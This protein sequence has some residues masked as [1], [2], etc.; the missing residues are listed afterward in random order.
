[1]EL[2]V[3][4]SIEIEVRSNDPHI[5]LPSDLLKVR[6]L[7]CT[8]VSRLLQ[9]IHS[10][11]H[12]RLLDTTNLVFDSEG[13][14]RD[15]GHLGPVSDYCLFQSSR[16]IP[17]DET[18]RSLTAEVT[19]ERRTLGG[20]GMAINLDYD[21]EDMDNEFKS[22]RVHYQLNTLSMCDKFI[23]N[24]KELEKIS[25]DTSFGNLKSNAIE[26]V[27]EY[28]SNHE[29]MC[30]LG[31]KH[32][33]SDITKFK[34]QGQ[35]DSTIMPQD[36]MRLSELLGGIDISPS[37]INYVTAMFCIEHSQDIS[38][39][40][41]ESLEV[42][43][44]VSDVGLSMHKMT[45]DSQTT[46]EQVK[47]FICSI[48]KHSKDISP[49]DIKLIYRG[50]LLR[51]LNDDG[52]NTLILDL[53][54]AGESSIK[55][56][57]LF[58]ADHLEIE[59]EFWDN[60]SVEQVNVSGSEEF[61]SHG[62][63]VEVESVFSQDNAVVRFF[64]ESGVE[65]QPTETLYKK[66]IVDG[67]EVFIEANELEPVM[68]H[69]I[70]QG[71]KVP[72]TN[73]EY[74]IIDGQ[75]NLSGSIIDKIA[76]EFNIH[77]PRN[78]PLQK[79]RKP[80]PTRTIPLVMAHRRNIWHRIVQFFRTGIPLTILLLRTLYLLAKNSLVT[81]FVVLEFSTLLPVK[82]T[83]LLALGFTIR[84]LWVTQEIHDLWIIHFHLDEID[85]VKFDKIL[86]GVRSHLLTDQ[87]YKR[88]FKNGSFMECLKCDELED[89]RRKM[90]RDTLGVE[91]FEAEDED[92]FL[93][94][95]DKFI[96]QV[97]KGM[98]PL[99]DGSEILDDMLVAFLLNYERNKETMEPDRLQRNKELMFAIMREID[100]INI[101]SLPFYLRWFEWYQERIESVSITD[102][103]DKF[104]PN[105]PEDNL[106]H[107]T[108]KNICLFMLLF[109]PGVSEKVDAITTNRQHMRRLRQ[110]ADTLA[111]VA[112][113]VAVPVPDTLEMPEEQSDTSEDDDVAQEML[114]EH[115]RSD[116]DEAQTSGMQLHSD[117]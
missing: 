13:V 69:L 60:S 28:E 77:V 76:N 75:I 17:L 30:G 1:M 35:N 115:N 12:V 108:Y 103:L 111:S 57:V 70:I 63:E 5:L 19:F 47:E 80:S 71:V 22:I 62:A 18:C 102:V 52:T 2:S 55:L 73:D 86:S 58:D 65:I 61:T 95:F 59:H 25:L 83:I 21:M 11:I 81:L 85:A 96:E 8:P 7:P 27:V 6:V 3:E 91:G 64:T 107:A 31:D 79:S 99:E 68:S 114:R 113:P 56:H 44:F 16:E 50:N 104:V 112:E 110:A 51:I 49:L 10:R 15:E 33:P 93:A 9:Y 24:E 23:P 46:V 88:L 36:N 90:Y 14:E 106:L 53:V 38:A 92:E 32:V 105:P 39:L 74:Q 40:N 89:D 78:N 67:K 101:E 82:F 72:I 97:I 100:K 42:I 48:Y 98:V 117:A 29:T 54:V 45:V 43:E 87:S 37:R 94:T 41:E 84:T 66:C 34:F 109:L 4:P 20:S 26:S 116:Q